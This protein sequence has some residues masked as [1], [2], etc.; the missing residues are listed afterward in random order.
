VGSLNKLTEISL[1]HSTISGKRPRIYDIEALRAIAILFVVFSH[2]PELMPWANSKLDY[3]HHYFAF[4][5]G[6]DLFFAISGF[7]IARELVP[8][9][10]SLSDGS[11]ERAWRIIL[12]FWIKR[13][14]R[15]LPSA[16]LWIA[17]TL[18]GAVAL[19]RS[20]AWGSVLTN[21]TGT[22]A[23][24]TQT[25]NFRIWECHPLPTGCGANSIYWSL[26]LEEQFYI[27]LPLA[28]LIFRK[29]IV[30]ALGI[31]AVVQIFLPREP[32]KFAWV[33][34]SDALALG[35]LLAVFSKDKLYEMFEPSFLKSRWMFVVPVALLVSLVALPIEGDKREFVPFSTGI[36]ACISAILVF[37]ASY[38]RD[39]I[40][41]LTVVKKILV[42]VGVRSFAMYL[43]HMP[44]YALTREIWYRIEPPGTIFGG[45]YTL[46]FIL[47]AT[48]LI[49]VMT[50]LTHWLVEIPQREKGRLLALAFE[51]RSLRAAT[52]VSAL[53]PRSSPMHVE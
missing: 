3:L 26:S 33:V 25:A 46:R 15:I 48:A 14:W 21:F 1:A 42:W 7:V 13:A 45:S 38:N 35:A 47:T 44:A 19:N 17:L 53:P 32:V 4:W 52:D 22:I 24:I 30:Y 28:C 41:R 16:W 6:V 8:K 49:L 31:I 34:R 20:G 5:T 36:I 11:G 29:R 43:V 18:V 27:L 2:L 40:V 9:I 39:Y 51:S 37:I 12:S 23:A 50:E 10:V